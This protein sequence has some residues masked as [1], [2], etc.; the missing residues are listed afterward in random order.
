MT[1]LIVS[2]R[3]FL[4]APKMCETIIVHVV[5]CCGCLNLVFK[6]RGGTYAEGV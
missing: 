5:L 3:S 4:N 1:K 6:S 2:F